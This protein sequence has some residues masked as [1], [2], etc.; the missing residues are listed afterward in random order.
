MCF[1][2]CCL[3]DLKFQSLVSSLIYLSVLFCHSLAQP[4]HTNFFQG[5]CLICFG[6][7][8]SAGL[9]IRFCFSYQS[10]TC[11]WGRYSWISC[12]SCSCLSG[13]SDQLLFLST[14]AKKLL[15]V[16]CSGILIYFLC[17]FSRLPNKNIL[18]FF[19]VTSED[20][21]DRKLSNSSEFV[22]IC[23]NIFIVLFTVS[24]LQNYKLV[25]W[26][27][28]IH[29]F[30]LNQIHPSNHGWLK[31]IPVTYVNCCKNMVDFV[32]YCAAFPTDT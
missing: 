30:G 8:L 22:E 3:I 18:N 29:V 9:Q 14:E 27:A 24:F 11:I 7:E 10:T 6:F 1:F 28:S 5:F 31:A 16:P 12:C 26:L 25:S 15:D 20:Y 32:S 23:R 4:N 2:P 19:H 13:K 21:L 17:L